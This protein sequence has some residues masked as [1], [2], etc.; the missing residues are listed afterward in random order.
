MVHP[1]VPVKIVISNNDGYLRIKHTQKAVLKGRYAG[2]D[3]ASCES[4]L[5]FTK[6]AAAFDLPPSYV[7]IPANFDHNLPK[8]LPVDGPAISEVGMHLENYFHRKLGVFQ[9]P[10]SIYSVGL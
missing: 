1:R 5:S 4:R 9:E 8:F 6:R 3:Q 2:T 7:R 10:L